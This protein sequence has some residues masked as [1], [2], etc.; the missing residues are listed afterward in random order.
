MDLLY[1]A[2]SMYSKRQFEKCAEVCTVILEKNPYDEVSQLV[3]LGT[4]LL[5]EIIFLPSQSSIT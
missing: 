5:T 2:L 3:I 4:L 1:V